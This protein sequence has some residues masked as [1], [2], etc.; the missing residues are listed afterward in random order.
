LK[1]VLIVGADF[2]PS[3]YPPALRIRYFAQ[4]LKEFGWEPVILT[5]DARYYETECD[6]ENAKLLPTDLEI[7]RTRAIPASLTRRFGFGDLGLRSLWHHWRAMKRVCRDRRVDLIFVPIPPYPSIVLGRLAHARFGIPY[8]IDY[9]DPY[10]TEYYWKLPRSQRPPKHALAYYTA[11]TVE[12]FAL[13]RAAAVVGVDTS[14]TADLFVRYPWLT[15]KS[16]SIPYGG[17]PSDFEYLHQ[18][19]RANP[20]FDPHDG[21]LHLSYVGRG[22]PDMLPSLRAVFQAV[23]IGLKRWPELFSRLRMHFV[24]TTY[25]HRAEGQYQVLGLAKE[26][27]LERCVDEHPGRVAYLTAIQIMLDSHALLAVGSESVHY[28]A[29]KIFPCI[30]AAR[31]L[32]AVFHEKSSVA[33]ILKETQAGDVIEFSAKRPVSATVEDIAGQ[34]RNLLALPPNYRPPTRWEAFERYTTKAITG[35]LAAVFDMAVGSS[36]ARPPMVPEVIG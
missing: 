19:P 9:I 23:I 2:A 8:V 6:E 25:A 7:I 22:G 33:T 35:R 17:E 16:A 36:V 21:F 12:P 4:H 5:T 34:L 11:R 27:A 24:G 28:T 26:M 15:V 1:R 13:K 10:V 29:S 3:S 14:Y 32:L 30:L 20:V 31:P 18:H